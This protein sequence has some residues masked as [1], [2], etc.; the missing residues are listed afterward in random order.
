MRGPTSELERTCSREYIGGGALSARLFCDFA[1]WEADPLAPENPLIFATGPFVGTAHPSSSRFA[2]CAR[3]PLTGI[4]GEATS[5][6]VF[7]VQFK[8]SGFDAVVI[9][10]RATAPVLVH[11]DDGRVEIQPAENLWGQVCYA[12]QKTIK[13]KFPRCSVACIGPAGENLVPLAAVMND[14][15]RAPA[16]EVWGQ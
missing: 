2:V 8:R 13:Q 10:G 11:L 12:T 15:G 4:W 16:G 7:G 1:V 14:A 5:G 6:G 3:S 9:T